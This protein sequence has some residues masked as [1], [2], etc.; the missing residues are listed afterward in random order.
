M[1][2]ICNKI[3]LEHE[4]GNHPENKNRLKYFTHLPDSK[5][6]NGKKCLLL[7]HSKKYIEHVK[8]KC[9]KEKELDLDTP[10]SEKSL[11]VAYYAVGA[12]VQTAQ[13]VLQTSK[14]VFA[15]VR[16]PGHHAGKEFGG[17]FCLFNNIAIAALY[18]KK[19]K[20]KIFILDFD[21]HHGNGTQDI[22]L[23]E[24]NILY[25]STHL[26]P[27]Y[28]G[29]G[30]KSEKNCINIPLAYGTGDQEYIKIINTC[31]KKE[32]AKFNP[33]IVA[34]SAGF[35]SFGTD[36]LN[37]HLLD[38]TEKSFQAI[39]EVIKKYKR[40]FVLEGGYSPENIKKGVEIFRE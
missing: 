20:Q 17:G 28:P 7:A 6:E 12:T 32:L 2:I 29:T 14:S 37:N 27:F 9:Q 26:A 22:I 36:P 34:V 39:N 13:K 3:F 35:D 23:G 10:C 24:N 31:L 21:L 11:E 18:L 1:E 19:Q 16:P 5:I 25:F 38:L 8:Q 30:M 4:T 15:L 33:D 40:F